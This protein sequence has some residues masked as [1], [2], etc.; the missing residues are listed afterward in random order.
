LSE[1]G[2]DVREKGDD[3]N[4]RVARAHGGDGFDGRT[5]SVEVNDDEARRGPVGAIECGE[6]RVGGAEGFQ[7]HASV[8]GGFEQFGLKEDVV[9][10]S[11]YLRHASSGI[12]ISKAKPTVKRNQL[13]TSDFGLLCRAKGGASPAP[14]MKSNIA[15]KDWMRKA[16]E[17]LFYRAQGI[18]RRAR[19]RV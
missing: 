14:T 13:K 5:A 11:E 19:H 18:S 10:Q 16:R 9:N 17:W 3:R 6:Q 7:F 2:L 12:Q 15:Q 8:F 1:F 4:L